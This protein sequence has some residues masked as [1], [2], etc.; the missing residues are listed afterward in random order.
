MANTFKEMGKEM[1]GQKNDQVGEESLPSE[2]FAEAYD[3]VLRRRRSIRVFDKVSVPE[4][5]MK[6]ALKQAILAPTSSNLQPFELHWVRDT[7]K[8]QKLVRACLSQPAAKTAAEL[9]VVVANAG[10]WNKNR[11]QLI[12]IMTDGGARDLPKSVDY[13]YNKLIPLVHRTDPLGI[14]NLGRRVMF[15]FRGMKKPTPHVS[16]SKADHR[17]WAQVQAALVAQTFMLSVCSQGYDSCPMGGFDKNRVRK[18]L[19]LP[20]SV[21]ISMVI[22]VGKRKPEGL[23]GPRFRLPFDDLVKIH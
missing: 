17:I 7:E 5:V 2:E 4:S 19:G 23:Y 18:T 14:A 9:V 8:K 12:D 16:E 11:K 10:S 6:Q 1:K 21:E 13:Y 20:C 22:S 3:E 15:F